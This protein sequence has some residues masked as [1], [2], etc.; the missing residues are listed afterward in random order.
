LADI[1]VPICYSAGT[2]VFVEGEPCAG[3]YLIED[4][5]VKISRFSKDGRE[6]ILHLSHPGDTFNDVAALDG[7]G[8]PVNATAHTDVLLWRLSREDLRA[9]ADRHPKFAWAL[10]EHMARRARFMVSIVQDLSMRNVRGRLA[11]L[12]LNQACDNDDNQVPR[13]LTQEEMASH[14]GT[15]REVVGRALRGL[16][17]EGIIEFDRH[18]I[19]ILDED[20][21]AAEAEI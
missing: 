20:R 14:L 21:L 13:M 16:A 17:D 7:Q 2:L 15:V 1:A 12:L 19:I 10:V 9:I 4:G 6:F 5:I 18:R 8:N 3:L 11:H